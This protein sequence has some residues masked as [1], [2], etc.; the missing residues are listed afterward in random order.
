MDESTSDYESTMGK[1]QD[2]V[3]KKQTSGKKLADAEKVKFFPSRVNTV[4][5]FFS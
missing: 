5:I 4:N 3:V 1:F 2:H